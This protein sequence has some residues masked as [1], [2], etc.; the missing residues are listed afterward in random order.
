MYSCFRNFSNSIIRSLHFLCSKK[1]SSK[2]LFDRNGQFPSAW[3]IMIK[4]LGRVCFGPQV[5]MKRYNFLTHKCICSNLNTKN[6]KLC[7]NHSGIYRFRRKFKKDSGGLNPLGVYINMK[8]C[9]LKAN[10]EGLG[11][12]STVCLFAIL[13]ILT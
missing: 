13:L 6:L 9:I 11:W 3:G 8:D 1:I 10:C 2:T 4:T 12:Q 5:K 7:D